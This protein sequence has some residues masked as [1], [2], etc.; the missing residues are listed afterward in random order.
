MWQLARELAPDA[1]EALSYGMPAL[2]VDGKGIIGFVATKS[3]LSL[4]P[5]S[6][7]VLDKVADQIGEYDR[8]KGALHFS[9]E[10]PI[11]KE[12]LETIMTTRRDE[13]EAKLGSH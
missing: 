5:Y 1:K 13:I 11:S 7:S 6:G 2:Q 10:R 8:T 12:L 9:L 4:Y 3:G